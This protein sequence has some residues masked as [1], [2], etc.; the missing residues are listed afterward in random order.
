MHQSTARIAR[1]MRACRGR[2]RSPEDAEDLIQD[3]LL[4]LEEFR[5]R[6][7]DS[8]KIK[9]AEAWLTA[10]IRNRSIDQFRR[11]SLL[12]LASQSVEELEQLDL[13]IDPGPGPERIIDGRQ[14]LD[15]IRRIL[16]GVSE[17]MREMYFLSIAGY[18]QGEIAEAFGVSLS[19]VE[20][21]LSRAVLTLM[22]SWARE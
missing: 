22:E 7:A 14:R 3:A 12:S 20:R 11:E 21:E 6:G 8:P 9:D 1:L 15:E 4:R 5:R 16:D 2:C 18:T 13:V 17:R 10:T 19:T